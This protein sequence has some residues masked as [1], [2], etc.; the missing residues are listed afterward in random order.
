MEHF[1]DRIGFMKITYDMG[2]ALNKAAGAVY[3]SPKETEDFY[4]KSDD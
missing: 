4:I 3:A 2:N 1:L